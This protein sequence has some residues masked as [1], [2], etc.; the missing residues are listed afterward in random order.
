MNLKEKWQTVKYWIEVVVFSIL[1][2]AILVGA[3]ALVA[4]IVLLFVQVAEKCR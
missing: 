3:G 4:C 2:G 1:C